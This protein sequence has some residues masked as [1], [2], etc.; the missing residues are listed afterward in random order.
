MLFKGL[1]EERL[2]GHDF[3]T[4]VKSLSDMKFFVKS[5]EKIEVVAKIF[6]LRLRFRIFAC[7][8]L[9]FAMSCN[10]YPLISLAYI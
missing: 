1:S 6:S 3:T 9:I 8:S 7:V 2:T 5:A 10:Q 4:D